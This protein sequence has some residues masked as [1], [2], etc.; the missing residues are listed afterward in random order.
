ME[1]TGTVQKLVVLRWKSGK[2]MGCGRENIIIKKP[3]FKEKEKILKAARER[4]LVTYEKAPMKLPADFS[5][6]TL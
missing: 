4:Q 3:K 2:R 6:Q 5:T 1:L